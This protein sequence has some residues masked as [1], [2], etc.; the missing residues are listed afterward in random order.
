MPEDERLR[1][2]VVQRRETIRAYLLNIAFYLRL[3]AKMVPNV[4][5][6]PVIDRIGK[7]RMIIQNISSDKVQDY[8]EAFLKANADVQKLTLKVKKLEENEEENGM[9]VQHAEDEEVEDGKDWDDQDDKR[10]ITR[11]MEKNRGLKSKG[12]KKRRNP[13]VKNRL[14]FE[15]AVKKR[16]GQVRSVKSESSKYTGEASGIRAGIKKSVRIRS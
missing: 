8:L 14:A 10:G 13:R 2:Y 12:Q 4:D 6:H 15:E 3:K 7:L 1:K 9:D 11:K 5:E 16:K